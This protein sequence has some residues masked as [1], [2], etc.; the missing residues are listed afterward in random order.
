MT[1]TILGKKF[2]KKSLRLV[3]IWGGGKFTPTG[4]S[5]LLT[6]LC[7]ACKILANPA[8]RGMGMPSL[9]L[10]DVHQLRHGLTVVSY[11][12]GECQEELSRVGCMQGMLGVS[13]LSLL[14]DW[15]PSFSFRPPMALGP[16]PVAPC[17]GFA[18]G[19]QVVSQLALLCGWLLAPLCLEAFRGAG[20]SCLA[21]MAH[22]L[23]PV[24]RPSRCRSVGTNSQLL[25]SSALLP[26][27][28]F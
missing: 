5:Q 4:Q 10:S 18:A 13:H 28:R 25:L 6:N 26:R 7:T 2:S 12:Q 27:L 9:C 1:R 22:R 17:Q 14:W 3:K 24:R 21:I 19:R 16:A 11:L 8:P 15:V 23:A 20:S